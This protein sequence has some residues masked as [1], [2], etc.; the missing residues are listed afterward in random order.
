MAA[1]AFGLA[2]QLLN[3]HEIQAK[4]FEYLN[5]FGFFFQLSV[6]L[7]NKNEIK[8]KNW[9]TQW[10]KWAIGSKKL[11]SSQLASRLG[12]ARKKI[13]KARLGSARENPARNH[14]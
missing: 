10:Q 11:E 9:L 4:Y 1:R 12:S 7:A 3:M 8:T 6:S 2:S 13:Q 14:V 5:Y